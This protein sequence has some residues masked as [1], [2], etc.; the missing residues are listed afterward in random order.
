[1]SSLQLYLK[2]CFTFFLLVYQEAVLSAPFKS[3][4]EIDESIV[5]PTVVSAENLI[6]PTQAL[7][8]TGRDLTVKE[9]IGRW[10]RDNGWKLIWESDVDFYIQTEIEYSLNFEN[11]LATL[12]DH[13]AVSGP[14]LHAVMYTQNKVLIIKKLY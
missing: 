11:A 7:S 13:L 14:R 10:C 9:A 2:I 4:E 12:F 3:I 6:S 1:M 5:I 8:L